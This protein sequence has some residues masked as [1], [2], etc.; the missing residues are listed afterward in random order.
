MP[1]FPITEAEIAS[2]GTDSPEL[3]RILRSGELTRITEDYV[4]EDARAVEVQTRFSR[5]ATHVNVSVLLTAII[6]SLILAIGLLQPWFNEQ[7]LEAVARTL[8]GLLG[9][10]G[11]LVGGYS[12]ARL[13]ELNAGDL[14]GTWM[15]GRARAEQL[16]S[17]YFDRLVARAVTKDAV[18]QGAALKLVNVHLLTN[19]LDYFLKRGLRHEEAA[20]RWLRWAAFA[21]GIASI[22]VAAGGMAGAANQPWILVVAALGTIGIAVSAFA[23]AQETIGQERVR[24]Q[25]F[26]N[27][28][29]ALSLLGRQ[30][31]D[32]GTAVESGSPE[33]LVAF[34]SGI[35]Q[36]L[37]LE[38]G[39]FLDDGESIRAS[40]AKLGEEIE[41]SRKKDDKPAGG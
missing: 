34:T 37:S 40:I 25:R 28:R 21:S 30:L 38:L 12:A 14:A 15:K 41:K 2:Y 16:R 32:V 4:Q 35:N 13:Y 24:A 29:T 17:E 27:N 18:T 11:L 20:G 36:Q 7:G 31:D 19:Q 26:R 8:Q 3:G 1:G 6:G 22:G 39:Q 9:I 23:S 33:A 5:V 10:G